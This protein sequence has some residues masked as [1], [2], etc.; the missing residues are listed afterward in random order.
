MNDT[1]L[2]YEFSVNIRQ[3]REKISGQEK[4]PVEKK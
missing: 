2:S 1:G 3:K 4:I